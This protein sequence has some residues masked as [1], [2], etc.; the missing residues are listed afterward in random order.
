MTNA[1][2]NHEKLQRHERQDKGKGTESETEQGTGR[3]TIKPA[4]S[5]EV[6]PNTPSGEEV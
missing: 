5:R 2:K 6:S 3:E 4:S 1:M